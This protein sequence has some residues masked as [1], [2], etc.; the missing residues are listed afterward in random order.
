MYSRPLLFAGLL[1]AVLIIRRF[2]FVSKNLLPAGFALII[3]RFGKNKQLFSHSSAP[4]LSEV[5]VFAGHSH[6]VT[7]ANNKGR[8]C[9]H[10]Q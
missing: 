5:L 7:T 2:I 1:L 8:L 10:L 6:N 3:R 4:L 9:L